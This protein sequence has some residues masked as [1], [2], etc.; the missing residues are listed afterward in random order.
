MPTIRTGEE[1][2]NINYPVTRVTIPEDVWYSWQEYGTN[3]TTVTPV[4][5]TTE[6]INRVWDTWHQA[7]QYTVTSG[8]GSRTL[9]SDRHVDPASLPSP[10]ARVSDE[11]FPELTEEERAEQRRIAQERRVTRERER[12]QHRQ[13]QLE[14]E[15]EYREQQE[16]ARALREQA[17]ARSLELLRLVLTDEEYG[18]YEGGNVIEIT[19]SAGGRYRIR[20]VGYE[21]NVEQIDEE[22][23]AIM[24]LCAHPQMHVAGGRLPQG[25]AWVG[26]V[27]AIKTDEENFLSV[28]NV[29]WTREPVRPTPPR[30]TAEQVN[31]LTQM[32]L[33]RDNNRADF[34][35]AG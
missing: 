11:V 15:R 35:I 30:A 19:G 6:T 8:T 31:R 34:A 21:G 16:A 26:Q 9:V 25:D 32:V 5:W 3:A 17:Q 18:R 22:G 13:R 33:E 28:A 23:E 1:Y 29:H 14:R 4:T 24:R 10:N 2:S 12:Q 20:Q 7:W 27:L